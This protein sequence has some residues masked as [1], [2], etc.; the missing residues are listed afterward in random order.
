LLQEVDNNNEDG[1]ISEYEKMIA[2]QMQM[3]DYGGLEGEFASDN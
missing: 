2:I 1:G 3:E